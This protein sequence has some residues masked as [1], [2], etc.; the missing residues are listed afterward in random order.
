W[1]SVTRGA[2]DGTPAQCA[3]LP[4]ARLLVLDHR[5][6][7]VPD[8]VVG[9]IHLGG[10]GE[11]RGYHGRPALTAAAFLPDPHQAGGRLY[12]TGDLGR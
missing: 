4:G 2:E 5:L 11:A 7:P 9:E 10:A 12:R 8:G 6:E 3:A 1:A